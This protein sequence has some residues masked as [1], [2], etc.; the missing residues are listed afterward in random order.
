MIRYSP[1]MRSRQSRKRRCTR[2]N[3]PRPV[4]TSSPTATAIT[5]P[6]ISGVTITAS[7]PNRSG[8]PGGA[9]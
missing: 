1:P 9:A 3:L 7:Q 6:T 2:D 4:L 5:V 8:Q